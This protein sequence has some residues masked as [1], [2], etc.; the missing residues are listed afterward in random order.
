[1]IRVKLFEKVSFYLLL[2]ACL[3]LHVFQLSFLIQAQNE[4]LIKKLMILNPLKSL[5]VQ[6]HRLK[7]KYLS[8]NIPPHFLKMMEPLSL[9]IG[10]QEN[11]LKIFV[12]KLKLIFF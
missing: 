2:K 6:S 8:L 9:K 3:Y 4:L 10:L 12:L 1:M 7:L 11:I 5:D